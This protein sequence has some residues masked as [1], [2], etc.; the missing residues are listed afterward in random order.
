MKK[1]IFLNDLK[2]QQSVFTVKCR[3]ARFPDYKVKTLPKI[4]ETLRYSSKTITSENVQIVYGVGELIKTEK[5]LSAAGFPI[6]TLHELTFNEKIFYEV[7]NLA[8]DIENEWFDE[9]TAEK[10]STEEVINLCRKYG[11]NFNP[12]RAIWQQHRFAG[13]DLIEFKYNIFRLNWKLQVYMAFFYEDTEQLKKLLPP[14]KKN[15]PDIMTAAAVWLEEEARSVNFMLE[16]NGSCFT[17]QAYANDFL[18]ASNV[19]LSII[20]ATEGGAKIKICPG[21][22]A[23]HQL[24]RKYCENCD[25]RTIW[26]R[27]KRAEEKKRQQERNNKKEG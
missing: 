9:L 24:R 18:D 27:N 6:D 8:K 2:D 14:H 17:L 12:S 16:N 11:I 3:L 13:F 22:G 19:I 1:K 7:I 5:P 20:M 25:R 4:T 21:C 26:S 10:I 23:F 15:T